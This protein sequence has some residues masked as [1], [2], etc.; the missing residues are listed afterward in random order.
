MSQGVFACSPLGRQQSDRTWFDP[1]SP[2]FL[3]GQ[4]DSQFRR[5]TTGSEIASAPEP[6]SGAR[7]YRAVVSP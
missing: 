1:G 3:G 6:V 2:P 7:L 4:G 5:E